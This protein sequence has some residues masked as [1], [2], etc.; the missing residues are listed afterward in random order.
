M[1]AT[2]CRLLRGGK[3][4]LPHCPSEVHDSVQAKG[5][6]C[7]DATLE[8]WQAVDRFRMELRHEEKRKKSSYRIYIFNL[9][10]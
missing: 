10:D 8:R 7:G 2:L 3:G 6:G 4:L 9:S 5:R 1:W